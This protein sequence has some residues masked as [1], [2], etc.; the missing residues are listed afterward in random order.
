MKP[1]HPVLHPSPQ[2]TEQESSAKPD[3]QITS[4][5]YGVHRCEGMDVFTCS[6]GPHSAVFTV[7]DEAPMLVAQG[8]PARRAKLPP[9]FKD[10]TVPAE[11]RA[12]RVAATRQMAAWLRTTPPWAQTGIDLSDLDTFDGE[13]P[14]RAIW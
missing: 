13:Q 7:E 11:T 4:V 2:G 14:A 10:T 1:S 6:Q 3:F 12:W 5:S 9:S 8:L